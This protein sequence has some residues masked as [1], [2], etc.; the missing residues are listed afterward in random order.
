TDNGELTNRL[1]HLGLYDSQGASG[2][3]EFATKFGVSGGIAGFT[4]ADI[5]YA[6]GKLFH[7]V[8]TNISVF[9]PAAIYC[10]LLIL[11]VYL[12]IKNLISDI[13]WN[14]ILLAAICILIFA[15]TA[16]TS[17]LNTP[18]TNAAQFSYCIFMVGSF[19]WTLKSGKVPAFI[20]AGISAFL[21]AGT[22]K[23]T[24][25]VAIIIAG[26][27]LKLVFDNRE[28]L[29]KILCVVFALSTI[30][31]SVLTLYFAPVDEAKLYNSIFYGVALNDANEAVKLGVDE[32]SA[33]LLAGKPAFEEQAQEYLNS[34]VLTDKVSSANVSMHYLKNPSLFVK[35]IKQV[36]MN[37][38][39]ISTDYLGNYRYAS[40]KGFGVTRFFKLYS[41]IKRRILPANLFMSLVI[42]FGMAVG[43]VFYRKKYAADKSAKQICDLTLTGVVSAL[44]AFVL[45]LIYGGLAQIG[46]NMFLY[47]LLFDLCLVSAVVGGTKLL[48]IRREAL[49]EKYGVNQ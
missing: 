18:Y 16:Y 21:F 12:I 14:N 20:I 17:F 32:Q 33:S 9:I 11:G 26:Y 39:S 27:F 31:T 30:L 13:E 10:I 46:F 29:K 23:I 1:I 6:I 5:P 24:A 36:A 41:T 7:P 2:S 43:S 48:W 22:S 40:G 44:I 42:L 8:D 45:P 25:W 4:T 47:N 38:T 35:N 37:S 19:V 28:L 49:K 34:V 3:G 15:D